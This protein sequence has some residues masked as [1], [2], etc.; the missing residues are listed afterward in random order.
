MQELP[1][2][3]SVD[4]H[5][6]EPQTLWWD[7]LPESKRHL[8]PRV[9]RKHG[10]LVREAGGVRIAD[11][12]GN[13]KAKWGDVW[14]YDDMYWPFTVGYANVGPARQ[15]KRSSLELMTYDEMLPGCYDQTARL[16]DM[17]ENK[18]EASMCFPT[19]PRF[20]GQ[21]FKERED[22][23]LAL[24]CLK[25]YND[26]M[27]DE[28]CAGPGYGRLIPL[29]LVPIWDPK[30]ATEEVYRCAEKGSHAICFPEAMHP[31]G[32]QTLYSGAWEP[33]LRACDETS[34]V[35]NM[36][37]G[38]SSLLPGTSPDAS[39][40]VT[41]ALTHENAA[42]A[43]CDWVFSG[44]LVR[45]PKLKVVLSEA[46]AGWIPFML[47][48]MDDVWERGEMYGTDLRET[49]PEPPSTLVRSR[50]YSCI[51]NDIVGLKARNEIGMEHLMFEVD[52]P[53]SD[54]T[55]PLSMATAEKLIAEAGLNDEE[56]VQ[57][58]RGNAIECYDL[59]RW[60]IVK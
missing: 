11:D 16:A 30:L 35:I 41:V 8:G 29:T 4:D 9:E 3:I 58:V 53:H 31:L 24:E 42:H 32:L 46:Q 60:G 6:V 20:C 27:I 14:V 13:P 48:R 23:V 15:T 49:L 54:S 43:L 19:V 56:A 1:W 39:I 57:F 22:K 10:V 25:I 28:W 26:W 5:V 17:T 52:Y 47:S 40:G 36:H 2:I 51:F 45:H 59:G 21:I 37:I 18:V 12:P 33:M 44:V 50:I 38:S 7:R 34:T 55:F